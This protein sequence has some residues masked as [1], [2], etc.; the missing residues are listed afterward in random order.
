MDPGASRGRVPAPVCVHSSS[1]PRRPQGQGPALLSLRRSRLGNTLRTPYTHSSALSGTAVG[2]TPPEEEKK[3]NACIV[4]SSFLHCCVSDILAIILCTVPGAQQGGFCS[5][6]SA[7]SCVLVCSW[8]PLWPS[9]SPG[10][11]APPVQPSSELGR[12]GLKIHS[13][14]TSGVIQAQLDSLDLFIHHSTEAM[15]CYQ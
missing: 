1:P 13:D 9:A 11:A 3:K 7:L 8:I 2:E 15:L 14:F 10:H 4:S 6:A 5:S 12:L